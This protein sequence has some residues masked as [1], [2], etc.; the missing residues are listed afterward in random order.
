MVR[1]QLQIFSLFWSHAN[2]RSHAAGPSHLAE[3][4]MIHG[5]WERQVQ[6]VPQKAAG[7]NRNSKAEL[8]GLMLEGE[9][10]KLFQHNKLTLFR[11][12]GNHSDNVLSE[13]LREL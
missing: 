9:E 1:E 13:C 4:R 8:S 12:R 11:S 7:Q 3:L 10:A 6:A 5:G 2:N